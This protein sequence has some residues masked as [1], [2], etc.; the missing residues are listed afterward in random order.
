MTTPLTAY[1]SFPRFH[2]SVDCII[3]AVDNDSLNVLLIK[4]DFE[5]EK[6]NGRLSEASSTTMRA[7]TKPPEEFFR[8]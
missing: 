3:F 2:V 8:S 5:P 6:G 7:L 1:S 4:R